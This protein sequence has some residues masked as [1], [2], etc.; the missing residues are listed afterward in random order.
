MQ[1]AGRGRFA[2]LAAVLCWLCVGCVAVRRLVPLCMAGGE[3]DPLSMPP[4]RRGVVAVWKNRIEVFVMAKEKM[5]VPF[6]QSVYDYLE[7]KLLD[8]EHIRNM[9]TVLI[10]ELNDDETP[11]G[12]ALFGT[13]DYFDR[14]C[15]ELEQAVKDAPFVSIESR[16]KKAS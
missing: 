16:E 13:L 2:A 14:I 3:N 5:P 15:A 1:G 6:N 9:F 7:Y 8:L 10:M 11:A 12:S 4:P